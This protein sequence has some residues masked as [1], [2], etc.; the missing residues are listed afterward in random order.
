MASK[1]ITYDDRSDRSLRIHNLVPVVIGTSQSYMAGKLHLY[2]IVIDLNPN[3][4]F[5][6]FDFLSEADEY[7]P[8]AMRMD[9]DGTVAWIS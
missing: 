6:A 2:S 7:F 8:C 5:L 4:L 3:L 9:L 1:N